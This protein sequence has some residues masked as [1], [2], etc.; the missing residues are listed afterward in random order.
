MDNTNQPL[1]CVSSEI[2]VCEKCR[3]QVLPIVYG[4]PT[5]ETF[6]KAEKG[7]IILGGCCINGPIE[8]LEDL[9]CVKCGQRYKVVEM[10]VKY[11]ISRIKDIFEKSGIEGKVILM[12]PILPDNKDEQSDI[13]LLVI[14]YQD[15][16][17]YNQ[18][19]E[20]IIPL[21]ELEVENGKV[22]SLKIVSLKEWE[23][24]VEN[25]SFFA[26]LKNFKEILYEMVGKR[27]G[28]DEAMEDIKN[29]NLSTYTSVDDMIETV[30]NEPDED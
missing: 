18:E 16:T 29:G 12:E 8:E 19:K 4:Y 21:T 24:L 25:K 13:N 2:K 30:L 26:E 22:I 3:S 20:I 15:E 7:E 17:S 6:E 14:L 28:L 27:T 9:V 11:L 10:N 5:P 1:I 23:K